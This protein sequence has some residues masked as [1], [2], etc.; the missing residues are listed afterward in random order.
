MSRMTGSTHLGMDFR[1]LDFKTTE[2]SF[3]QVETAFCKIGPELTVVVTKRSPDLDDYASGDEDLY[4]CH[5]EIKNPLADE[6]SSIPMGPMGE[7]DYG[8]YLLTE[9]E[10]EGIIGQLVGS[11]C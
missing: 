5:A 1:D 4:Y 3:G 6:S 7:P 10:V 11:F 9:K 2:F 8:D